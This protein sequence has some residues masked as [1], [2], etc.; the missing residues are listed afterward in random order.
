MYDIVHDEIVH[1][2]AMMHKHTRTHTHAHAPAS[3]NTAAENACKSAQ[4]APGRRLSQCYIRAG[5]MAC[6]HAA[7]AA[8]R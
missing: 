8:E 6:S 7:A 3:Q 2:Y 1:T 5:S 4:Q